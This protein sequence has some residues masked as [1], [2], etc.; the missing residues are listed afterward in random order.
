MNYNMVEKTTEETLGVIELFCV[1]GWVINGCVH[2]VKI[3][4]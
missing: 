3:L 2:F 1:L 4:I